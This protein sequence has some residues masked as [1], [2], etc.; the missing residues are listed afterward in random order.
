[1]PSRTPSP[2]PPRNEV[3]SGQARTLGV[4]SFASGSPSPRTRSSR[5]PRS[6]SL[7]PTGADSPPDRSARRASFSSDEQPSARRHGANNGEAIK[8][9]VRFRPMAG[10][11]LA[12]RKSICEFNPT[13]R[14]V[15]VRVHTGGFHRFNY[16]HVFPPFTQQHEVYRKVS[17]PI[18]AGMFE[19]ISGC[20]LAYGQ[21]GSGKTHTMM[22]AEG[23]VADGITPL[24]ITDIFREVGRVKEDCPSMSFCLQ[25]SF[26]EIYNER[27]YDLLKVQRKEGVFISSGSHNERV[28]LDIYGKKEEGTELV[29]KDATIQVV[30]TCEDALG[31]LHKGMANREVAETRCNRTSSRGHAVFIMTLQML[32]KDTDVETKAQLYLCDLAG[33]EIASKTK[34][35]GQNLAEA[36]FINS[37]LTQLRRVV[38]AIVLNSTLKEPRY[39]PFRDSILTRLLK[40]CLGGNSRTF[41]ICCA[42]PSELSS[43]ETISTLRFG[44]IASK[45]VNT[46]EKQ[47]N[48][49]VSAL[50]AKI[51]RLETQLYNTKTD[52]AKILGMLLRQVQ[53]LEISGVKPHYTPDQ[54]IDMFGEERREEQPPPSPQVQVVVEGSDDP[55]DR[56]SE[57][58][59]ECSCESSGAGGAHAGPRVDP[60]EISRMRIRMLSAENKAQKFE[61]EMKKKDAELKRLSGRETEIHGFVEELL[62][63]FICPITQE[64]FSDP[65]VAADGQTYERDT[66][67]EWLKTRT[68]SPMTSQPLKDKKLLPNHL[69]RSILKEREFTNVIVELHAELEEIKG[70][71]L[72]DV[73]RVR[74]QLSPLAQLILFGTGRRK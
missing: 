31:L 68:V 52:R 14:S 3:F 73:R 46:T 74:L 5:T 21:T 33:S 16:H 7:P 64:P 39:I 38:E 18:I 28:S 67:T 41:I 51:K 70:M 19:G 71:S 56:A 13:N 35:Q 69:V 17:R 48:I 32:D 49:S 44:E 66:I 59:Y 57:S 37:S 27:V 6:N 2:A 34:T 12:T 25:I 15:N 24:L 11:E 58:S 50:Q 23:M 45:I 36:G 9:F 29:V 65:V 55:S 63:F 60:R 42:T 20:I 1:M 8:V 4:P 26:L 53:S 62:E 54:L 47:Q 40:Q 61:L 72:E 30:N 10:E 22:G 43:T